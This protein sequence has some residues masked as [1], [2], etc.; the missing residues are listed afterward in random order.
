MNRSAAT[1][2]R[3]IAS[4]FSCIV[5]VLLVTSSHTCRDDFQLRQ[6]N[7]RGVPLHLLPDEQLV[8]AYRSIGYV[9][10]LTCQQPL[11][12]LFCSMLN[13][14]ETPTM[15]YIGGEVMR[16]QRL[17][18]EAF[19]TSSAVDL[20]DVVLRSP[21]S[22]MIYY[23][24]TQRQR[25][26]YDKLYE[27]GTLSHDVADSIEADIADFKRLGL[28]SWSGYDYDVCAFYNHAINEDEK[29]Y[30][31]MQKAFACD[32]A[33]GNII[34]A[35]KMAG[36]IGRQLLRTGDW[37]RSEDAFLASLRYANEAGDKDFISRALSWLARFRAS[38]GYAAEAESLLV[39][40]LERG[41][42]TVDPSTE[43]TQLLALAELYID[44]R[45]FSRAGAIVQRAMLRI[46][47][48]LSDPAIAANR[49]HRYFL[50][51][52]L[53]TAMSYQA[54][55]QNAKGEIDAASVSMRSALRIGGETE[56]AG[57]KAELLCRLG[58]IESAAGRPAEAIRSYSGALSI[59]KRKHDRASEAKYA[60]AVGQAYLDRGR[61][62]E[63]DAW[64][65]DALKRDPGDR[66]WMQQVD[67]LHSMAR[68]QSGEGNDEAAKMF[69]E[70]AVTALQTGLA[71]KRF[72]ASMETCREKLD[73][74]CDDLL[75]LESDH[76]NECDSLIY[77]AELSRQLRPAAWNRPRGDLRQEVR[78]CL[79]R[80]EWIPDR[81]LVIQHLVTPEKTIVIAIDRSGATY[82]SIAIPRERLREEIAA[83]IEAC[84]ALRGGD[85]APGEARFAAAEDRARSL[86]RLLLEPIQSLI[87]GKDVLCFIP[88]DALLALPFGALIPPGVPTRF[89][90]E[91]KRILFS[92]ALLV[93]ESRS[94]AGPAPLPG[95][96]YRSQLLVGQSEISPF[97][98]RLYPSLASLPHSQGELADIRRLVPNAIVLMG[99]SACKDSVIARLG[100]ADLIHIATHTVEFPAYGGHPALLLAPPSE[101]SQAE[102]VGASLLT[103]PEIAAMNFSGTKL[104][105]VSSCE[106]AI[107]TEAERVEGFGV[108]GAFFEAG[109]RSV[110]ATVWPI[111]DAAARQ[112]AS[113]FY[114]ELLGRPTVPADALWH[115]INRII[116]E[117]RSG[118]RALRR[119]D[120]WGPF[121]LL[122][123]F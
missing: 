34:L 59:A 56:D 45:E 64:F 33:N 39:R 91:G 3:I 35:S 50:M 89:L 11:D 23:R 80:R 73:S 58:D 93:L 115:A 76:F 29:A 15:R 63:A 112:F 52:Y 37:L 57:L 116:E 100:G 5:A 48:D 99:P 103:E 20:Y 44:Q 14:D 38:Q 46:Q 82:R 13:G 69:C 68:A 53:A 66:S 84:G 25:Y 110:I 120:E 65:A 1:I 26:L 81:A 24:V 8:D 75:V 71:E 9:T 77:V 60:R 79:E 17:C 30:E 94:T 92:P 123:S 55:I 105:V 96:R 88:D 113:A 109:A 41:G 61:F 43:V 62:E 49:N 54:S 107:G 72:E 97:I 104:A 67:I 106:S 32:L 19:H 22:R 4:S 7:P 51:V 95:E 118:G 87:E 40:A 108:G 119:I 47:R 16:Y 21:A 36:E 27:K 83:F 18:G 12:S 85:D 98:G 28:E 78:R 86:Y 10:S 74:I 114:E 121:I 31:C 122:G 90:I 111:E 6:S 42:G 2:R 117:D 101:G 70:R 102:N